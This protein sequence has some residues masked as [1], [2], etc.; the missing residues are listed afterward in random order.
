MRVTTSAQVRA[1]RHFPDRR[2]IDW[3]RRYNSWAQKDLATT[4]SDWIN[5]VD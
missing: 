5:P 4:V 1:L 2:D 3:Q